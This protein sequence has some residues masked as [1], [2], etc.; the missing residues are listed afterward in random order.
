M[1]ESTGSGMHSFKFEYYCTV[2]G[3]GWFGLFLVSFSVTF[4]VVSFRFVF[5]PWSLHDTFS[6]LFFHYISHIFR[7][8]P[9]S[10]LLFHVLSNLPLGLEQHI[11]DLHCRTPLS[12]FSISTTTCSRRLFFSL[13]TLTIFFVGKKI[14]IYSA[15]GTSIEPAERYGCR[16]SSSGEFVRNRWVVN[17][18]FTLVQPCT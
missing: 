13:P 10:F 8:Y 1:G 15:S 4:I 9:T 2:T 18:I 12:T 17:Y 6:I 16:S 14:V 7:S 11:L 5:Y 3:E